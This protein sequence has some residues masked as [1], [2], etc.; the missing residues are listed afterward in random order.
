MLYEGMLVTPISGAKLHFEE[1]SKIHK[2]KSN[3]SKLFHYISYFKKY[4]MQLNTKF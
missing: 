1:L 3:P 2:V 4:M